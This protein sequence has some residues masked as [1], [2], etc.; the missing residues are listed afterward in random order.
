[1]NALKDKLLQDIERMSE[2]ELRLVQKFIADLNLTED[3][4]SDNERELLAKPIDSNEYVSW[5]PGK[6]S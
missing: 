5:Q 6:S 2:R 3:D 1:M 4:P